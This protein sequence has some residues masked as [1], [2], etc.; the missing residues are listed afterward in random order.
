MLASPPVGADLTT[1]DTAA[2][3]A[4]RVAEGERLHIVAAGECL[5]SIARASLGDGASEA[6][7]ARQVHRIWELN[8]DKIATGD[9]NL[10]MIGTKLTLP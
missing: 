4:L 9:P 2:G 10:L 7:V 6:Q 8:K 3:R 5:W 1:H